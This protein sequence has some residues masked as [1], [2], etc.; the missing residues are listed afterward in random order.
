[1]ESTIWIQFSNIIVICKQIATIFFFLYHLSGFSFTD[2][3][4]SQDSMG[5]ERTILFPSNNF[6]CSQTFRHLFATLHVRW[7]SHILNR[8]SCIYQANTRWYLTSYWITIWLID[9]VDWLMLFF[10]CLL[11][12]L[13]LGFYY[14]NLRQETGQFLVL[15]ADWLTNCA[16]HPQFLLKQLEQ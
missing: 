12:D 13:I 10:V 9:L 2:T 11:D 5:R 1:M 6:A 16:S 7:L 4:D 15:Q 3:G 8:T 14:S